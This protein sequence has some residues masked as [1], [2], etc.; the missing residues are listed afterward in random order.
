MKTTQTLL[1]AAVLFTLAGTA[2]AAAI[3]TAG[4]DSTF[5]TCPRSAIDPG[6]ASGTPTSQVWIATVSGAGCSA[7]GSAF[8]YLGVV[9]ATASASMQNRW[10]QQSLYLSS[11]AQSS[12]AETVRPGMNA[13]YLTDLDVSKLTLSFVIG[14]TG[15]VSSTGDGG[16]SATIGYHYQFGTATGSGSQ[17]STGGSAP[18]STSQG[19]WGTITGT[20]DI[21]RNGTGFDSFSFSMYGSASALATMGSD[22]DEVVDAN[23]GST[24][25][26]GGIQSIQAFDSHGN[27]VTLG[28]DANFQ[29]LGET[30]GNNYVNPALA[31]VPLPAA[32]W[33]LGSGL[34]GLIGFAKKRKA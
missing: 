20:V 13:R 14:A 16:A 11:N 3:T 17:N 33:L 22:V 25:L 30:T 32:A 12:W 18:H 2:N 6:S 5:F 21:F 29:L 34:L 10:P 19:T 15:D 23:F 24:M 31:A 1:A 9:G 27:S 8:S 7:R 28:S 4:I 26:W